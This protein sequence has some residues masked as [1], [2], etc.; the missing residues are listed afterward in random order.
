MNAATLARVSAVVI[1][2]QRQHARAF[3]RLFTERVTSRITARTAIALTVFITVLLDD[4]AAQHSLTAA[5]KGVTF[6]ASDWELQP[7]G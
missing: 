7:C 4:E 3:R 1:D 6:H 5:A 2:I